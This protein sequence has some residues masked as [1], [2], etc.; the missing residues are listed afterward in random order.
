MAAKKK[1]ATKRAK[2]GPGLTPEENA[3]FEKMVDCSVADSWELMTRKE[4]EALEAAGEK[5]GEGPLWIIIEGKKVF[6]RK[7]IERRLAL[8]KDAREFLRDSIYSDDG[9]IP[10]L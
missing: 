1:T 10:E 5:A 6:L 9:K 7:E 3:L 4:L 8:E 2:K